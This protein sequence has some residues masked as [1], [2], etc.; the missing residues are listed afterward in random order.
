MTQFGWIWVGVDWPIF[1]FIEFVICPRPSTWEQRRL[2]CEEISCNEDWD[3]NRSFTETLAR[4]ISTSSY[5]HSLHK[6]STARTACNH[7]DCIIALIR[8][9]ARLFLLF[10]SVPQ[11]VR[12]N[13]RHSLSR[14]NQITTCTHSCNR[15]PTNKMCGKVQRKPERIEFI[16]RNNISCKFP[17]RR[18]YVAYRWFECASIETVSIRNLTF[19]HFPMHSCRT[20]WPESPEPK[21]AH[22]NSKNETISGCLHLTIRRTHTPTEQQNNTFN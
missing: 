4:W 21:S 5:R 19:V 7:N 17:S 13:L 2:N 6:C 14:T 22:S 11:S 18:V 16:C 15:Q 3:E 8:N 20:I 9:R 1:F 10:I 12:I